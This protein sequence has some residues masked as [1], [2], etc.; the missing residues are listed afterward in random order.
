LPIELNGVSV[1]VNGA[2]AGLYYVSQDQINFVVP[3]GLGAN[4]TDQT[5]PV[6]INNNGAVIRST[7]QIF[8]AQPDIFTSTNGP[9]GRAALFNVTNPFAMLPEPFTV[10]STNEN[11]ETVATR[12]RIML[13]GVRNV[14]TSQITVRINDTDIAA[15][16]I[17]FVGQ[18]DTPGFDQI[19][20]VLPDTLTAGDVPIIVTVTTGSQTF[21]SRPVD[22]GA[23]HIQIN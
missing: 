18:G 12:L 2:A 17:V 13:T 8:A 16:S 7:M 9:D 22:G 20:I 3:I 21:S 4:S 10:T 1:S 14:A 11:G 19:D 23:P 6:V 15:D 5:Y